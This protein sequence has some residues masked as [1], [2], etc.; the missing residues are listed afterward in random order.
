MQ[1]GEAQTLTRGVGRVER[2]G[3]H[4]GQPCLIQEF[5]RAPGGWSKITDA[6]RRRTLHSGGMVGCQQSLHISHH[7]HSCIPFD[8]VSLALPEQDNE[9][10]G[11][12]LFMA[13][14]RLS[15][16][17]D[18]SR[19]VSAGQKGAE[20]VALTQAVDGHKHLW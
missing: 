12:G 20:V 7:A 19:W 4:K 9:P 17:E 13:L 6:R 5:D 11:F 18:M 8:T 14:Y 15:M 2:N 16:R 3:L 1:A 10:S